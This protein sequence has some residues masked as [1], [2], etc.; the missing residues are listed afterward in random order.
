M[1]PQELQ[2][3]LEQQPQHPATWFDYCVVALLFVGFASTFRFVVGLIWKVGH[4][5]WSR[6]RLLRPN[7]LKIRAAAI[8]A[9]HKARAAAQVADP[10]NGFADAEQPLDSRSSPLTTTGN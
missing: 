4:Y 6:L 9:E 3:Y 5:A 8:I 1:T 10:A 7:P 2:H